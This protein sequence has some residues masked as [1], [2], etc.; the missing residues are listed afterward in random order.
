MIYI[1]WFISYI[2]SKWFLY[3]YSGLGFFIRPGMWP[4]VTTYELGKLAGPY[5]FLTFTFT[6]TTTITTMS[7]APASLAVVIHTADDTAAAAVRAEGEGEGEVEDEDEDEYD[8]AIGKSI[9][10]GRF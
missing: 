3:Y 6:T 10:P 9:L 5:L 2:S 1:I 7:S 8:D 4:K